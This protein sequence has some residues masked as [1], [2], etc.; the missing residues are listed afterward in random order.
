VNRKGARQQECTVIEA[1]KKVRKARVFED[2]KRHSDEAFSLEKI[3]KRKR[4][5][6]KI[7]TRE[8]KFYKKNDGAQGG[9]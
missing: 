5:S 3:E 1:K 2:K 6:R 7:P 8:P 9:G 4:H